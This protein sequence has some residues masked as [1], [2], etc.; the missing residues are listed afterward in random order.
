MK[1]GN[2]SDFDQFLSVFYGHVVLRDG[3]SGCWWSA[4][5]VLRQPCHAPTTQR[6][7][8][9]AWPPWWD[10]RAGDKNFPVAWVALSSFLDGFGMVFGWFWNGF[11]MVL[12]G[13]GMVFGWFWD[14]FGGCMW[15][16]NVDECCFPWL[17]TCT[18]H[19]KVLWQI[20]ILLYRSPIGYVWAWCIHLKMISFFWE[21]NDDPQ[22]RRTP[23]NSNKPQIGDWWL[24]GIRCPVRPV[25]VSRDTARETF[26]GSRISEKSWLLMI[27]CLLISRY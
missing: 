9:K 13:F 14:G 26:G 22:S 7:M 12:D 3:L 1:I 23:G 16:L 15:M 6:L 27:T 8:P 5:L 18:E 17:A 20:E 21:Q 19:R 2:S 25:F 24:V 4:S 11:W 10:H